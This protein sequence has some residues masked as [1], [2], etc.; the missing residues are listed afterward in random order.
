MI[1]GYAMKQR[2][3]HGTVRDLLSE[4]HGSAFAR[5]RR[6]TFPDHGFGR[7]ILFELASMFLLPAPGALGLALRRKLLRPFFGAFGRNVI[8]GRN[9]VFRHPRRIF[10]GDSVTIDDY[11]L[12]DARGCGS[13]G[14][15]LGERTIVSRN[16]SIKSKLGPIRVGCDV[17]VGPAT[18]IVSHSGVTIGDGAAIAGGCHITGGTFDFSDFSRPPPERTPVSNGPIEIGAGVWLATQVTVLDAV[19]I[20]DGAVVSAGSVVTQSVAARTVV[21]GNPAR[22]VFSIP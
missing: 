20:G 18:H 17:N 9:C 3:S 6:L 10:I 13:E 1:E 2:R 11:C 12:L 14:L 16:C 21:Q 19:H 8:I 4:E 22:K 15:R 5:Y 7:F